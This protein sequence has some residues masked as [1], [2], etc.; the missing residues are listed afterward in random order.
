MTESKYK[1]QLNSKTLHRVIYEPQQYTS[2]EIWKE[3]WSIVQYRG[4]SRNKRG[5][6]VWQYRNNGPTTAY[7]H[8]V[9]MLQHTANKWV[10]GSSGSGCW[11]NAATI[12]RLLHVLKKHFHWALN[13]ISDSEKN[14]WAN[15]THTHT[16]ANTRTRTRA[17]THMHTH[18]NTH[19]RPRT[20][21]HSAPILRSHTDASQIT[22]YWT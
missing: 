7:I 3:Q 4:V 16:H 17:R 8:T 1:L 21:A 12:L 18:A 6:S 22:W 14:C 13:V 20:H 19:T 15:R 11:T 5:L 2:T 9:A 10:N